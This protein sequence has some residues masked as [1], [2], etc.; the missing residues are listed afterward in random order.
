MRSVS[1]LAL[2]LASLF[3]APAFAEDA[4]TSSEDPSV[5][6]PANAQVPIE[7]TLL[8]AR[9]GDDGR[10]TPVFTHYSP[11]VVVDTGRELRCRLRIP[12]PP[13][14]VAPG[15][16]ADAAM[17]CSDVLVAHRDGTRFEMW[18]GRKRVGFGRVR[19]EALDH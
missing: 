3:A 13:R 10:L 14:S 4:V 12:S 17:S 1:V 19:L 16:T 9:N 7:F 8:D 5:S 18:E 11:R 2:A 6:F 15:E